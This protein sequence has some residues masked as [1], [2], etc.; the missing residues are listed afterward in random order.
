MKIR[1]RK[2]GMRTPLVP[3]TMTNMLQNHVG[4]QV[5]IKRAMFQTVVIS[6][7]KPPIV[8]WA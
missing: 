4:N 8:P 1:G 5:V 7:M 3:R 6:D 2:A